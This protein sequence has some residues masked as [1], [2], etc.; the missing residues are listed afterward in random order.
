MT[1]PIWTTPSLWIVPPT[2]R[3]VAFSAEKL[4]SKPQHDTLPGV[5]VY[6][7]GRH[8]VVGDRGG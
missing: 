6:T 1:S 7:C 2:T 5:S 8:C 3:C 4:T